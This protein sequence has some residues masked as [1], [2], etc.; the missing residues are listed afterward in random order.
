[1]E[2]EMYRSNRA[3]R[4]RASLIVLAAVATGVIVAAATGAR[5]VSG[6]DLLAKLKQQ[7]YAN[8]AVVAAPPWSSLEPNGS[9]SG[10]VPDLTAAGLKIIGVPTVKGVLSTYSNAIPGLAAG[11]WDVVS[12]GLY[13]NPDRCGQV[14]F[15][16]PITGDTDSF[17]VKKGNPNGV[18]TYHD[19]AT[20]GLTLGATTGDY[21]IQLAEHEGISSSK[22]SQYPTPTALASALKA[23]RVDV[24]EQGSLIAKK[25]AAANSDLTLV[26]P[27]PDGLASVS[28]LAFPKGQ[29]ALRNAFNQALTKLE[30]NG[31][32][33]A[34][35]KKWGFDPSVVKRLSTAGACKSAFPHPTL[36]K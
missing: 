1:V 3:R 7:G 14:L 35:S 24:I 4:I 26:G 16:N 10:F 5:Q 11:R 18:K 8:V 28:A 15:S 22:I 36:T 25:L 23:G 21:Q 2:V 33:A 30:Q 34:I 17:L 9:V 19:I 13:V 29:T 20:K 31:Q 12:S 32:F 27:V 6:G